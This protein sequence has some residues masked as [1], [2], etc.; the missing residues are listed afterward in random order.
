MQV[1]LEK[2]NPTKVKMTITAEQVEIDRF[3][4][5]AI[6]DLG[7]DLKIAGFRPGKAPASVIEKNLDQALLQNH[8][9][10]NIIND[11][12]VQA[13]GAKNVRPVA[14]PDIAILKFV[15][16]S[17]LEFSAEVEAVGEV[18]LPD[19]KN[20]KI[21]KPKVN[22]TA[23]EVNKVIDDLLTR[24]AKKVEVKRAAKKNDEVDINFK[25]VD[26]KTKAAI[27]G[28]EGEK[29][30][31]IIGSGNFIP[32]FEEELVGLK[33]GAEKTFNITFPKDY[34]V[35]D[36]QS[37]KVEFTVSINSVNELQKPKLDD[38]FASTIGPFKTLADL[39]ADIK[40]QLNLEK[41]QQA[42]REFDNQLVA[43]I[44]SK[45]EVNIP[46][47]LVEDEIDRIEEE[48]KRNTIYQGQT[49]QEHLDAEG[50]TAEEHRERQREIAELRVKSGLILGAIS[51]EEKIEV[52]PEELEVRIQLLKGQYTDD[53]MQAELDKPENRRDIHS[54]MMTEKTLDKLRSYI[55]RSNISN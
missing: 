55:K 46:K 16:F 32:G 4:D 11:L 9:L 33:A 23:D 44:A 13:V 6:R 28:A 30:P 14:N 43:E 21:E 47:Q 20:I 35:K 25:G 27:V 24:G 50:V 1:N 2:I 51:Q 17:T 36:L 10:E 34:G 52:T 18:K 39:K 7:R 5:R 3:K 31:L 54:R 37:K 12:Y 19:Y 41:Q 40:K 42:D 38:Q 45:T 53:S 48:E 26:A 29:Y 8:F 15:P 22:V 49:W